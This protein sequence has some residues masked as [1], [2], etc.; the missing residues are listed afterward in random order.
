[1]A[2]I[3]PASEAA[4]FSA[5]LDTDEYKRDERDYKVAVHLVITALLSP[6][7]IEGGKFAELIAD[8]FNISG[9]KLPDLD[10]LGIVPA[11]QAVIKAAATTQPSGAFRNAIANLAGGRWGIAQFIWIPRAVEHGLGEQIAEAFRTLVDPSQS[12]AHRIDAFRD[13]LYA[14]AQTLR[15]LGGFQPNWRLFTV[16]LSFV[17]TVLGAYDPT[18]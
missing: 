1:M 8:V 4:R 10:A 14:G 9:G 12:L 3:I 7:N 6:R 2:V 18:K 5:R 17:A 13:Q 11:Q 16:S 15:D